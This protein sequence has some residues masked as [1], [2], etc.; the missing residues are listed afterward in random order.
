MPVYVLRRRVLAGI[1]PWP[2][3]QGGAEGASRSRRAWLPETLSKPLTAF[4]RSSGVRLKAYTKFVQLL[5][6]VQKRRLEPYAAASSTSTS[7]L[8]GLHG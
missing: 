2:G 5:E 6:R 7:T 4:R 8:P 3:G 1:V